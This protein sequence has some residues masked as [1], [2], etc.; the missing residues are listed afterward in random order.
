MAD[1]MQRL[2]TD[3]VPDANVW[4]IRR[5]NDPETGQRIGPFL[6]FG[7]YADGSDQNEWI[8]EQFTPQNV[9]DRWGS[10]LYCIELFSIDERGAHGGKGRSKYFEIDEQGGFSLPVRPVRP[11]PLRMALEQ[12]AASEIRPAGGPE[13]AAS[14]NA[15]LSAATS[16]PI[17]TQAAAPLPPPP[18]AVAPPPPPPAPPA[19]SPTPPSGIAPE[20]GQVLQLM[21]Y[22]EQRAERSAQLRI[23]QERA[24][25]QAEAKRQETFYMAMLQMQQTKAPA[26]TADAIAELVR[27]VVREELDDADDG[28][29]ETAITA[30]A[31]PVPQQPSDAAIIAGA[32]EKTVS[33]IIPLVTSALNG[34][35][36]PGLRA[37]SSG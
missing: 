15:F 24:D 7:R 37:N 29:D 16:L 19:A 34:S 4:R 9:F 21:N 2:F 25:M 6:L 11:N 26:L 3:T 30:P 12:P 17:P 32:I 5:I 27:D 20:L 13:P 1:E 10:G 33:Q 35:G 18:P 8:L 36:K 23:A 28:N 22:F 31:V 14:V